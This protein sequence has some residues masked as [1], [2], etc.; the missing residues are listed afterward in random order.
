LE[1]KPDE[2]FDNEIFGP[3]FD[4]NHV[5]VGYLNERLQYLRQL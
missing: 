5:R 1:G 3:D 4:L 2:F